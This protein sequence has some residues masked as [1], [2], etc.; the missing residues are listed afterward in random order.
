MRR[1]IRN[2]RSLRIRRGA[3]S[4]EYILILALVVLPI[5]LMLPGMMNMVKV[6][7]GRMT[8]LIGL[9]FP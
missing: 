7:F 9:P 4:T 5:A 2:H 1:N 3:T 8:A 6:Y